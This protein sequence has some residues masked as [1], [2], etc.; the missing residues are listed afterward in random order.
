MNQQ[1]TANDALN[2]AFKAQVDAAKAQPNDESNLA[3]GIKANKKYS[4]KMDDLKETYDEKISK[5]E[6]QYKSKWDQLNK[7]K[8]Q[9]KLFK[10]V[11][12]DQKSMSSDEAEEYYVKKMNELKAKFDANKKEASDLYF[13]QK[14]EQ[15]K[16]LSDEARDL[17][18]PKPKEKAIKETVLTKELS[19][20]T[21]HQIEKFVSEAKELEP[22]VTY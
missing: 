1:I 12:I 5:L 3:K 2:A 17:F 8:E 16:K 10:T 4:A 11:M 6:I 14:E 18:E 7:K 9:A 13:E 20:V 22:M 19:K 15:Q 21:P